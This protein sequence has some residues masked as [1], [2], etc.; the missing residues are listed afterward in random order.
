MA[1]LICTWIYPKW[2]SYLSRPQRHVCVC[3]YG[4]HVWSTKFV[5]NNVKRGVRYTRRSNK[6]GLI[7]KSSRLS[8]CW[9]FIFCYLWIT[10]GEGGIQSFC[11][12]EIKCSCT[13]CSFYHIFYRTVAR[14]IIVVLVT[15]ERD[16]IGFVLCF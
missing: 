11:D 14:T 16:F 12:H 10:G 3:V 1:D 9:S 8:A 2:P 13:H 5:W 7:K 4:I 15:W 6:L